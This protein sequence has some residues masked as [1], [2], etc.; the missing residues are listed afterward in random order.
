MK[1]LKSQVA[2]LNKKLEKSEKNKDKILEEYGK[3]KKENQ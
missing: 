3:L 1:S 2:S